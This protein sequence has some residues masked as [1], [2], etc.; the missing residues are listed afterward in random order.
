MP[1]KYPQLEVWQLAI[2][3]VKAYYGLLRKF[4]D[5][6]KFGLVAQGR[7]AAV[8]IALNVAEGSGRRTDRDFSLFVNRAISSLLETDAILRIGLDLGYI[9]TKDCCSIQPLM[10]EEYFKLVA[11]D[12]ALHRN[13]QS[14]RRYS[15][16]L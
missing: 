7:R 8:S 2:T 9:T 3:Y 16:E 4:P 1:L 10:E 14:R 13:P 5:D 12:K 6:E 15:D 11:F